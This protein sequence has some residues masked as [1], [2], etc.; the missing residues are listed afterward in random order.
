[1]HGIKSIFKGFYQAN[2]LMWCCFISFTFVDWI[3]LDGPQ[4]LFNT[5]Y[6]EF[7]LCNCLFVRIPKSEVI[8][9]F[10]DGHS[11]VLWW[12]RWK[13]IYGDNALHFSWHSPCV[14]LFT[15]RPA[16]MLDKILKF[17][18]PRE[19]SNLSPKCE[20]LKLVHF[21]CAPHLLKMATLGVLD[22]SFNSKSSC[23]Y[24]CCFAD[25]VNSN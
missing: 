10:S 17:L 2:E 20:S 23:S 3:I 18:C 22:L 1:M 16:Q 14:K 24:F 4:T 12:K 9:I 6:S 15:A 21:I 7:C 19:K 5:L 13:V 8:S 25:Y 11:A